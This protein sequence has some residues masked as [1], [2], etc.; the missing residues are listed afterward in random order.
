MNTSFFYVIPGLISFFL[1]MYNGVNIFASLLFSLILAVIAG[2]VLEFA[3]E[4]IMDEVNDRKDP[5]KQAKKSIDKLQRRI[6]ASP[7]GSSMQKELKKEKTALKRKWSKELKAEEKQEKIAEKRYQ[8]QVQAKNKKYSDARKALVCPHCQ[9]KGTVSSRQKRVTEETREKG[10]IGGV[11][12]RKTITD[13]GIVN[14][15][16]CSNCMT[17]WTS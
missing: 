10:I 17:T 3:F 4:S 11:I 13:K 6:N 16:S 5:F 8:K 7:Y 14:Q 2:F 1:Y 12:G 15:F 9:S